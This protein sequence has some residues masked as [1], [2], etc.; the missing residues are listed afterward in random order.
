LKFFATLHR[1]IFDPGFYREE[2][3]RSLKRALSYWCALLAFVTVTGG[4]FHAWY[5]YQRLPGPLAAMFEGLEIRDG[6]LAADRPMPYAPA[7]GH[8]TEI[9]DRIFIVNPL[10]GFLPDSVVWFDTVAL[11][12]TALPRSAV[13]AFTRRHLVVNRGTPFPMALPYE[14]LFGTATVSFTVAGI[15]SYLVR[16]AA[17]ILLQL[18]VQDL[19]LIVLYLFPLVCFLAFAAYIL[20]MQT[21]RSWKQAF[22]ASFYAITPTAVGLVLQSMAG[23][24]IQGTGYVFTLVSYF[25]LFRGIRPVPAQKKAGPQI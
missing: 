4:A 23:T 25:V 8:L 14:K 21:L 7:S 3:G 12:D 11:A 24:N 17:G 19:A 5:L 1:T 9:A 10:S 6:V 16:Q 15:R 22:A 2:Q 13:I 18:M 20:N